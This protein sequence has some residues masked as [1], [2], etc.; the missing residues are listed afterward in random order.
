MILLHVVWGLALWVCA[1]WVHD[2]AMTPLPD[3][4]FLRVSV[5]SNSDAQFIFVDPCAFS[6]QVTRGFM[7]VMGAWTPK[8]GVA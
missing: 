5:E 1:W 6:E 2:W 4:V 8:Q 7:Q 3:G